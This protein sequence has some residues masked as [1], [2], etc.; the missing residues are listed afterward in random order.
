[1]DKIATELTRAALELGAIKL[2]PNNPFTW[3]SGYRMPIYNDNRLLMGSYQSRM[4]VA[5]GFRQIIEEE[6]LTP[7][8]IAGVA[9]GGIA[10]AATLANLLEL[11][12]TYI[13]DKPKAHGVG[14]QIEGLY[15]AGQKTIV[16]EDLVSTGKSSVAAVGAAKEAGLKVEL[17]ISIFNY[18]FQAASQAFSDA[19][20][21]LRSLLTFPE[22]VQIALDL[23]KLSAEDAQMLQSWSDD[24]FS[25]GEKN[26]FPPVKKD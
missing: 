11:P 21:K 20:V 17:C 25:W 14:R 18:G 8:L 19:G 24:P 4:L 2:Q 1:M 23:K 6:G 12:L 26:G 9:T 16:I 5:S 15:A 10:P 3:T 13:R 7:E 22:L